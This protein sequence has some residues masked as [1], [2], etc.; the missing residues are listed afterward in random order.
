MTKVTRLLDLVSVA[1]EQAVPAHFMF[2]SHAARHLTSWP[3][4]AR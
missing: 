4:A 3:S 1:R 2:S